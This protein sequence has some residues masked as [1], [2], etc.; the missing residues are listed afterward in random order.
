MLIVNFGHTDYALIFPYV[1]TGDLLSLMTRENGRLEEA[2][3]RC[4]FDQI[5]SAVAHLH[6]RFVCHLD[7]K[8]DN[9]LVDAGDR[10]KIIDFGLAQALASSQEEID[11]HCGSPSYLSPEMLRRGSMTNPF[12][13]DI[14]SLGVVLYTMIC[15]AFPFSSPRPGDQRGLFM[16]IRRGAFSIPAHVSVAARDLL[17]IMLEVETTRR[18]TIHTVQAHFWLTGS[19]QSAASRDTLACLSSL[20]ATGT[21]SPPASPSIQCN[22]TSS[23]RRFDAPARQLDFSDN[24][25]HMASARSADDECAQ[26]MVGGASSSYGGC[27]ALVDVEDDEASEEE[28]EQVLL[29]VEQD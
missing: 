6:E 18:A 17:G 25:P 9:I 15:A 3:A 23:S 26:P 29:A 24:E 16:A 2:R 11:V 20:G 21:P 1:A 22:G 10:V 8:L 5:V 28:D 14:W 27:H 7:L 12:A 19:S 13:S 4:L